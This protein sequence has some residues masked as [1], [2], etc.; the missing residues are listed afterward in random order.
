[1]NAAQTTQNAAGVVAVATQSGSRRHLRGRR[2][3]LEGMPHMPLDILFEIFGFLH[4]RDVLNLARTSKAFRALLMSR[5]STP[6][7][8][9]ARRKLKTLPDPPYYLSEPAYANLLFFPHCH[10][11]LKPNIQSIIWIFAAR[12][13]SA[14][15]R[16]SFTLRTTGQ[17]KLMWQMT[18]VDGNPFQMANLVYSEKIIRKHKGKVY[19]SEIETMGMEWAALKNYEEREKYILDRRVFVAECKAFTERLSEWKETYDATK[20][21]E[22]NDLKQERLRAVKERLYEEGW[23]YILDNAEWGPTVNEHL[24]DLKAVNKPS[25]LTDKT[26]LK[27]A[28][29]TYRL[30]NI[31]R[32]AK[33]DREPGF[34]ELAHMPSIRTLIM[35]D[36]SNDVVKEALRVLLY[37]IPNLIAQWTDANEQMFARK[38]LDALGDNFQGFT[39]DPAALLDLA[40]VSFVCTR[41]DRTGLRWP[42]ILAHPCLRARRAPYFLTTTYDCAVFHHTIT[43]PYHDAPFLGREFTVFDQHARITRA[44]VSACGLDPNMATYDEVEGCGVRFVSSVLGC[45]NWEQVEDWHGVCQSFM[46]SPEYAH[47][48]TVIDVASHFALA[49]EQLKAVAR[50]RE[51]WILSNTALVTSPDKVFGCCMCPAFGE[52]SDILSHLRI[53][54]GVWESESKLMDRYLYLHEDSKR[55]G[56]PRVWVTL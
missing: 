53:A 44:V 21:S 27:T 51:L 23:G 29:E 39:E 8:K 18:N 35:Q 37:S 28:L 20:S 47:A 11:C 13:C 42:G 2:G 22:L 5:D 9:Q 45:N 16:S 31:P 33:T 6:F 52:Y 34:A 7:W 25:R 30:Q 48:G 41:C 1:M 32:T 26:Y 3:G 10:I 19:K 15:F 12:F 38:A 4:P 43:A 36:E 49:S 50:K 14:C 56:A 46:S 54:H 17:E 24:I 40:I 55:Q